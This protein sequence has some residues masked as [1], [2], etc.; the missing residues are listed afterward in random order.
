MTVSF[1]AT[2]FW[3]SA[4]FD[5]WWSR[6]PGEQVAGDV[7]LLRRAHERVVRV[8]EEALDRGREE[9]VVADV[10]ASVED[11]PDGARVA[12]TVRPRVEELVAEI[13]RAAPD[14]ARPASVDR[15]L[16]L[17]D[18]GVDGVDRRRGRSRRRRRRGGGR[19][20]RPDAPP[21]RPGGAR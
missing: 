8:R 7:E 15:V 6:A 13:G 10:D 16:E 14:P 4:I 5:W 18:L 19:A 9:R 1:F 2:S 20:R 3:F 17:L 11:A 12:A 21:R